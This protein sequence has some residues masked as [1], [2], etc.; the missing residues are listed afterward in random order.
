[1]VADSG[2]QSVVVLPDH[3]R[4]LIAVV[5]ADM[6]GYSRLIGLDDAG[7][8]ERLR[9]LRRDLIDPALTRHGGTLVNTGGD[10]LLITFDSII[11]AMRFAVDMQRGVPDFDGDYAQDRRMR[12]RL[13]VNVGDVIPDGTNLHGDGVNIAARLQSV[14]P[15]GDIC[16]SRVVRD[17]IGNRLGLD[18]KELGQI[19][20][21]NIARPTEAFLLELAS[22]T[23][24]QQRRWRI[25]LTPRAALISAAFILLTCFVGS[26]TAWILTRA[27]PARTLPPVALLSGR[28]QIAVLPLL[29]IGGGD[30][31]FAEGLT[32]DIIAALGRFPEIAVRARGAVIGYKDHPG[33]PGDIARALAVRF[34][35]EGSVQRGP[36]RLRVAVRLLEAGTGTVLWSETYDAE[37]KTVFAMQDDITRR[38]AGTVSAHLDTLAIA[39][40]VAKPPDRLEAYDLVLRGR[41]R[42]DLV[43]RVGT[44]EARVLFKQAIALDPNYAAAHVDLS[45][46]DLQALVSGWSGDPQGTLARAIAGGQKAVALQDDNPTA[47]AVLGR[48]LGQAG[49]YDVALN[50]L[51]RAVA[52]N[53]SD[54]ESLACYGVVLGYIGDSKDAILYMEEAARYRPNRP[55]DE[56]AALA[57][58]YILVGR[59]ADAARTAE[60]GATRSQPL[61]WYS[62]LLAMAYAQL[63]RTADAAREAANVHRQLPQFDASAFGNLLRRP[64]DRALVRA[65]LQRAHL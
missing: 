7:T 21:K 12:F 32:E 30:E 18:F 11:P 63:E 8:F 45:R 52:L 1:M 54:P 22:P 49:N 23:A 55:D 26:G 58:A 48:A 16:V 33:T 20:L 6:A 56:Y 14:C 43:T 53:P 13:G 34:I 50:E 38:V 5:Y 19:S 31:Y 25:K 65:A 41:Q 46:T 36:D 28:Q 2:G 57:L 27:P 29:T 40:A 35:V 60:Q 47:H 51:K 3:G 44:S 59:P 17:H 15:P 4:K 10:S 39:S 62:V 61:V 42:L 64:E 9:E 37:P 24:T